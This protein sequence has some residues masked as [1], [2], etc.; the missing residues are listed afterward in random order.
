[1]Y[2]THPKHKMRVP[3]LGLSLNPGAYLAFLVEADLEVTRINAT[4]LDGLAKGIRETLADRRLRVEDVPAYASG[5]AWDMGRH[6]MPLPGLELVRV[7]PGLD[8]RAAIG[9]TSGCEAAAVAL[10]GRRM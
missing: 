8:L 5:A 3:V 9:H 1:V 10:L 6:L 2:F 7:L 4:T